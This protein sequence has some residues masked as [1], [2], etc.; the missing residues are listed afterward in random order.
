[1]EFEYGTEYFPLVCRK[2]VFHVDKTTFIP[3][4]EK[5][6]R[7]LVFLRPRR[8][9]KSLLVSMLEHYY[10]VLYKDRFQ[11]LFGMQPRR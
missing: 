1:V 11:V 2:G 5:A 10:D 7:C 8:F 9:G 4:L 6:G 3:Q